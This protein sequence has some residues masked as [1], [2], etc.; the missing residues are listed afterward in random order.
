MVQFSVPQGFLWTWVERDVIDTET[1]EVD[2]VK[3]D[4]IPYA[5]VIISRSGRYA[6]LRS[7]TWHN[8]APT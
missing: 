5:P 8:M 1:N 2:S 4:Q 6:V 7:E 3:W